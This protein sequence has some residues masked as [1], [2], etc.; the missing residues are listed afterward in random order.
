[1]YFVAA[2]LSL[3]SLAIIQREPDAPHGWLVGLAGS[4]VWTATVLLDPTLDWGKWVPFTVI[5]LA[6]GWIYG[7]GSLRRVLRTALGGRL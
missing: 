5:N 7:V 6:N 1:M 2:A 3:C 4:F